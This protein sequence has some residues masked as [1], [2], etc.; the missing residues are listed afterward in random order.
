M[1][2]RREAR[3][4]LHP[5][6]FAPTH[7][8]VHETTDD[9]RYVG[10]GGHTRHTRR[11]GPGSNLLAVA[12]LTGLGGL[13]KTALVGHWLKRR[14]GVLE[15]AV[16]ALFWS[17]YADRSVGNFFDEL[18]R[19]A[20]KDSASKGRKGRRQTRSKPPVRSSGRWPCWS[21]WTG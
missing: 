11:L 7:A 20:T 8:W 13:G 2:G 12:S 18:S 3:S 15:R 1:T 9:D 16:R 21:S 17:F 10:R 14:G 5:L 4:G 19:F 6:P